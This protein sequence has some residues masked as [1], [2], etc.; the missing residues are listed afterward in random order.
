MG[1]IPVKITFHLDGTGCYYD[2]AE[3]PAL[4]G[5]LAWCLAAYHTSG[6]PPA[7]DEPPADIPLPIAT[8]HI[9]G[10]WGY[11]A[12]ALLPDGQTFETL[13]FWRSRFREDRVG[14]ISGTTD[15]GSGAY[16]D[17]QMPMP[18]ILTDK[19]VAYA[20]GKRSV[21]RKVLQRG[22]KY[23]GKK[24]AMGKGRVVAIDVDHIDDDLSMVKDGRAMRWLPKPGGTRLVRPRPPY[25][26]LVGRVE[27]CQIGDMFT[28]P[29]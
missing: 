28:L 20:V 1:S 10:Q 15:R 16:R 24:S 4:D 11:H 23:V 19:L 7:R 13:H 27:S 18:L 5:I 17:W 12:S 22:V 9:D 2:P 26:N 8:W 29:G 25:W 6:Q 3:P 21:I 14:L